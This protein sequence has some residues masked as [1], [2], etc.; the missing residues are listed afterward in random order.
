MVVR[1]VALCRLS[2]RSP[3][4]YGFTRTFATRKS[5]PSAVKTK[6]KLSELPRAKLLADG[7]AAVPLEPFDGGLGIKKSTRRRTSALF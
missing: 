1:F 5:A 6:K 7:T 2:S 3:Q 4:P